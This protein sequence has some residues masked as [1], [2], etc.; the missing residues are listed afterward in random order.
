MFKWKNRSLHDKALMVITAFM[1]FQAL[2][3]ACLIDSESR[4][5][6]TLSVIGWTW[7]VLFLYANKER[8][9]RMVRRIAE[10]EENEINDR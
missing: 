5:F 3:C 9:E 1:T 2:V 7:I 10:E 8:F 6:A 4:V